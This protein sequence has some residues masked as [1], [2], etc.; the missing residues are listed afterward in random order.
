[1]LS[2]ERE[3]QP[4]LERYTLQNLHSGEE[5]IVTMDDMRNSVYSEFEIT[6]MLTRRHSS[7]ILIPLND[8]R[9]TFGIAT[10]F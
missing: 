3:T 4:E 1:M 9:T 2:W 5:W 7:F 6:K 10:N 8:T